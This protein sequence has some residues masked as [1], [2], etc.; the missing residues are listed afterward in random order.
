MATP[1]ESCPRCG[2]AD[3]ETHVLTQKIYDWVEKARA[4]ARITRQEARVIEMM[5]EELE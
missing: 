4:L 5:A 1:V 3:M 2:K